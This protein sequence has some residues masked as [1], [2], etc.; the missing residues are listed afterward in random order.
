M[1]CKQ[2]NSGG[3][4]IALGCDLQIIQII[5]DEFPMIRVALPGGN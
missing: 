1:K 4:N 3:A 5:W 2:P